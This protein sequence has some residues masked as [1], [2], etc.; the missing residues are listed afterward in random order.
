MVRYAARAEYARTVEDM[1]A[2]RWRMLFLDARLAAGLA[3]RTAAILE[4][5]SG[6]PVCVLEFQDLADLY[7]TLP[8]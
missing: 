1:L 3:G 7:L 2:R 6:A 8:S 4:E 5:V